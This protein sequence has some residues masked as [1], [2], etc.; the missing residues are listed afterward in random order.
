MSELNKFC[1]IC[2]CGDGGSE[3]WRQICYNLAVVVV[4][5]VDNPARAGVSPHGLILDELNTPQEHS[6]PASGLKTQP[7][8]IVV[9]CDKTNQ[10]ASPCTECEE[11][12]CVECDICD[13]GKSYF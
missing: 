8:L 10:D 7:I 13:S 1:Q 2:Q 4:G 11:V 12:V 3:F 9:S 5:G 6:G